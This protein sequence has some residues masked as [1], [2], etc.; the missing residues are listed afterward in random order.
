M[1]NINA[2]S[3]LR[4]FD[5]FDLPYAVDPKFVKVLG[6]VCLDLSPTS[7]VAEAHRRQLKRHLAAFDLKIDDVVGDGD[8]AFTSIIKQLHKVA[9][10]MT[11][12]AQ[13]HVR[14]LGL[15]Q[16][17][18]LRQMFVN[19]M[20]EPD[21]ELRGFIGTSNP[22]IFIR[23][24]EDFRCPGFFNNELGDFVMKTVSSVLRIPIVVISSRESAC[25][26]PFVPP[27]PVLT[28]P[29][30]V[31]FTSCGPGHFDST[32]SVSAAGKFPTEP[33]LFS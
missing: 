16:S 25:C 8:C 18:A 27:D 6:S 26:I 9:P 30:Y 13:A 11:E 22:E 5:A 17:D 21:E 15:L 32:D 19:R 1:E 20:L 29:L 31:A 7:D 10:T 28:E 23:N 24:I 12:D 4:S 2:K 3:S 14:S 33:L